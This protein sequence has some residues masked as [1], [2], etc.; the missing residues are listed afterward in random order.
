MHFSEIGNSPNAY[1]KHVRHLD[2]LLLFTIEF[3]IN[4]LKNTW[5]EFLSF[6]VWSHEKADCNK[7]VKE[8]MNNQ[9]IC[10]VFT[11]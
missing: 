10:K 3:T 7:E 5:R 4:N 1:C 2:L 6:S 8:K 9:Q 11:T